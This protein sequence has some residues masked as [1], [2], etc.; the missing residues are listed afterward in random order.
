MP[1]G[2]W[3]KILD[4]EDSYYGGNHPHKIEKLEGND[5]VDILAFSIMVFEKQ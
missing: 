5:S 4:S 2:V 3:S 1:E